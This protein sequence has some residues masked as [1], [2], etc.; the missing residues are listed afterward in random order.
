MSYYNDDKIKMRN[1]S[2]HNNN[3]FTVAAIANSMA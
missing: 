1:K 3:G 2:S